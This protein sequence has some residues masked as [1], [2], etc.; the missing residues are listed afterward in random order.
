[1]DIPNLPTGILMAY[2]HDPQMQYIFFH[3]KKKCGY[4]NRGKNIPPTL[5]TFYINA[6]R[7]R[8]KQS[9]SPQVG[10]S[11]T[12]SFLGA[13]VMEQSSRFSRRSKPQEVTAWSS[14]DCV[15]YLS[16]SYTLLCPRSPRCGWH[17]GKARPPSRT[18]PSTRISRRIS[19]SPPHHHAVTVC[20]LKSY[21]FW[22]ILGRLVVIGNSPGWQN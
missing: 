12:S 11:R 1:M 2:L 3:V 19:R 4:Q 7:R 5:V 17:T 18:R 20:K 13:Y 15:R 22:P 8:W 21:L 14:L 16:P 10:A 6:L 9:R